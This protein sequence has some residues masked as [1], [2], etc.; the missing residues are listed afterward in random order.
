ML[1]IRE[2]FPLQCSRDHAIA[3]VP[4]QDKH[5]AAMHIAL[6]C[7]FARHA[8]ARGFLASAVQDARFAIS[9]FPEAEAGTQ[10]REKKE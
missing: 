5:M 9:Y 7:A 8:R 6:H 3:Y 1:A 2:Y 4:S 10:K